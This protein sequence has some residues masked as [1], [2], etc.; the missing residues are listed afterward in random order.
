MFNADV[1]LRRPWI[2]ITCVTLALAGCTGATQQAGGEKSASTTLTFGEQQAPPS[3][4]PGSLDIGFV[5]F[6]MLSYEPLFY[7]KSDGTVAPALAESWKYAGEGN[8]QLDVVLRGGVKFSDGDPVDADNVIK[9]LEYARDAQG[10]QAH[11]LAG[12]TF[13]KTGDLAFSI[14]L[15]DPDPMLPTI[16]TQ[17][18]GVGQIISPKGLAKPADLTLSNATHGAGPYVFDPAQSVSGDHYTYTANPSYYDKDKQHYQKVVIRIIQNQ[19]AAVNAARTGQLDVFKG[20][21]SFA[22]QAKSAGLQIVANPA[23]MSGLNLIDR[24]GKVA[25]PLADVRVRQA[26]NYAI[27][28]DA[29]TKALLGDYG[30]ATEQTVVKGG[31]GYAEA[32]ANHYAYNPEKAKQLLAEAGYPNGFELP[33]LAAVFAGFKDMGE[34]ISGQLAK[35]GI[36]LE[37]DTMTDLPSYIDNST[38]QKYPAVVFGYPSY[39]MYLQGKDL[40]LPGSKSFNGFGTAVPQLDALWA[41]AA[42]APDAQRPALD[43]K[44]EEYLVE[45][46]WYAPVSYTPVMYFARP[47]VSGVATSVGAPFASPTDWAPKS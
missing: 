41:Q 14:N 18:Y 33:V 2:L 1:R 42:A 28:R 34:A 4:N 9:S 46:A 36:K 8:K 20:D 26:I 32:Y 43:V 11:L 23:I 31:D 6:T 24:G 27:D 22:A 47:T 17:A 21:F 13:E 3:L 25:K 39:P 12:A 40:F 44:I 19:Q 29:V 37:V 30:V 15:K 5:D 7:Q 10:N 45:N 35:V 16:L 38:N